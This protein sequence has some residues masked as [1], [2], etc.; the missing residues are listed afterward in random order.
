MGRRRERLHLPEV[1]KKGVER[2]VLDAAKKLLEYENQRQIADATSNELAGR[3]ATRLIGEVHLIEK[4][5]DAVLPIAG[6]TWTD[7]ISDKADEIRD[8]PRAS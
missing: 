6:G 4:V 3:R 8:N 7:K 2:V 5:L 1:S